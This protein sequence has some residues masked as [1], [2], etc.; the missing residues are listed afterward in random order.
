M[1]CEEFT[2]YGNLVAFADVS[3]NSAVGGNEGLT[4]IKMKNGNEYQCSFP[5][6]QISGLIFGERSFREYG[7]GFI[8]SKKHNLVA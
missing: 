8:L 1:T 2:M 6:C 5:P 3:I 4:Y 7:K